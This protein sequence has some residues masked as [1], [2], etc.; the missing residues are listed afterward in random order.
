MKLDL[1][2]VHARPGSRVAFSGQVTLNEEDFHEPVTLCS[3]LS[4]TGWAVCYPSHIVDLNVELTLEL[5]RACS[6]CL[7]AI[8]TG[9][10]LE[11]QITFRG[12][13]T[14]QLLA[15]EFNYV[16]GEEAIDLR[17][18]LLSLVV[19]QLDPKPLCRPDC[20]GL[21]P[22]CGAN[23]NDAPCRCEHHN[24]PDPR[25]AALAQWLGK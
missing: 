6:R 14:E 15:D 2:K 8:P 3:P 22:A 11:D 13:E 9:V 5:E 17:P 25:L 12:T 23:L 16:L 24:P 20:R 10:A 7:S 4:V 18:A 1:K 19:G 21:C